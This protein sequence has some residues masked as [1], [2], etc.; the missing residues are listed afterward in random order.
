[1]AGGART[2]EWRRTRRATRWATSLTGEVGPRRG[3]GGC[4]GR[5]RFVADV[6][7]VEW[8][9]APEV[10]YSTGVEGGE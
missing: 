5:R 1:M 4:V 9:A 8:P 3:G 2:V 10:S 7:R 6:S